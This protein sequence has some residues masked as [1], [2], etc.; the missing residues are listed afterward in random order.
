V[1]PLND[2]FWV[3]AS[4][5]VLLVLLGLLIFMVVEDLQRSKGRGATRMRS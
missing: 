1:G 4:L 5:A 3:A 2:A